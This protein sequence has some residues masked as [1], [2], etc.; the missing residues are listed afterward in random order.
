[1]FRLF[2]AFVRIEIYTPYEGLSLANQNSQ[3]LGVLGP[4]LEGILLPFIVVLMST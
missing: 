1:M 3:K 4:N 2:K